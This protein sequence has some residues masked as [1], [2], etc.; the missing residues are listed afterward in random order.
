MHV[1]FGVFDGGAFA[2]VFLRISSST[3]QNCA[4]TNWF[5]VNEKRLF[6]NGITCGQLPM[7][8]G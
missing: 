5:F 8:D 2:W 7:A 1:V 3:P 6:R 4:T